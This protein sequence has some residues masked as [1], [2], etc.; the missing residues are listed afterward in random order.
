MSHDASDASHDGS[1][2]PDPRVLHAR[3]A[4]I[5]R[6]Q[7]V[8]ARTRAAAHRAAQAC[9]LAQVEWVAGCRAFDEAEV[10]LQNQDFVD[11]ASCYGWSAGAFLRA[12]TAAEADPSPPPSLVVEQAGTSAAPRGSATAPPPGVP[13][14]GALAFGAILGLI[15]LRAPGSGSAA[16]TVPPPPAPATEAT[17]P[18]PAM[19]ENPTAEIAETPAPE[20]LDVAPPPVALGPSPDDVPP[21]VSD[22]PLA[23]WLR[24]YAVAW[25]RRDVAGL[26][27]LGA[28]TSQV[29]TDRLAAQADGTGPLS[30]TIRNVVSRAVEHRTVVTFE[31]TLRGESG[32]VTDTLTFVLQQGP[33]G[34]V[35]FVPGRDDAALAR[36]L[37]REQRADIPTN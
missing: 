6:A 3:L 32:A 28:L 20:P 19:I 7:A 29:E 25:G 10:A 24:R 8:E 12:A 1:P 23:D 31:R 35:A 13:V 4:D 16:V 11:A 14:A 36:W 27:R 5:S 9:D 17:T 30:A 18:A 21:V 37:P 26:Q 33:R 22:R 15:A 2:F 34:L